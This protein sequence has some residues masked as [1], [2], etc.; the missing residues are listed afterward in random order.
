M[1]KKLLSVIIFIILLI[2][3]IFVVNISARTPKQSYIQMKKDEVNRSLIVEKIIAYRNCIVV[4]R[5]NASYPLS[6]LETGDKIVNCTGRV[7]AII[8][9]GTVCGEWEFPGDSNL[10]INSDYYTL[11]KN[12]AENKNTPGFLFISL[13]I[14]IFIILYVKSKKM[15]I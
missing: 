4:F 2:F 12:Q 11:V 15:I 5:G 1:R 6:P 13:I 9:N 14:A 10:S 8:N 3:S 7:V